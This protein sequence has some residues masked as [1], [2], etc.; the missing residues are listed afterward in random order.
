MGLLA[1]IKNNTSTFT[2]GWENLWWQWY[3]ILKDTDSDADADDKP[4]S[5][6]ADG[7][8]MKVVIVLVGR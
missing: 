6:D 2:L 4:D 5:D 3:D 8:I 1:K 7:G